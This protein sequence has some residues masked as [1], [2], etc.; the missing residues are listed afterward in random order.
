MTCRRRRRRAGAISRLALGAALAGGVL[1]ALAVLS[2]RAVLARRAGL[3]RRAGETFDRSAD[4]TTDRDVPTAG[5]TSVPTAE[6]STGPTADPTQ[7]RTGT[8]RASRRPRHPVRATSRIQRGTELARLGSRVAGG[9]AGDSARQVF[10]SAQR[11]EELRARRQL[12]T[13]DEVVE[14][15]GSMKGAFMKLGQM[16][17]YL[18]ATLDPEVRRTLAQLQAD[19]PPMSAEL[20][21]S[22]IEGELGTRPERLFA[23]WDPEPLAAASIGQ[24]HKA[25]TADGQ[26]V[27]VKVQYPGVDEAIRS[28]LDN[29]A[30]LLSVI[31]LAFPSLDAKAVVAELRER[32]G[33]ELDYGLEARNQTLFADHYAGHPF[34]H[35][36]AVRPDLS[37]RRVLT[38]ELVVGARYEEV[39]GWPQEQRNLAGEAIFRF[40]FGGLYQMHVFN[41]DPHP[42]NYLFHGDGR[43][44]FLDFGL[45]KWFEP[46]EVD[47]LA[48]MVESAVL[49][50]DPG[51]FR[52][53][54]ERAG[55]LKPDP[56]LTDEEVAAYF[57]HYYELVT[58]DR[59]THFSADYAT[60]TLRHFFDATSPVVRRANVPSSFVVLQRINLGLYAVLAGLEASGNWRRVAEEIWPWV[61]AP[62]STELGRADAEWRRRT[63]R[64]LAPPRRR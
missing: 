56:T 49:D 39:L 16:A 35:V 20:A 27:A 8:A 54:V 38:S 9:Y 17:S 11:R 41:G 42:G 1:A 64:G 33:E 53:A 28:D 10:A 5:P 50:P 23:E 63:G 47:L 22:V 59:V 37:S 60:D 31:R 36:P 4:S 7:S 2:R 57:D 3:P 24:V 34:I 40:V 45:V 51:R 30:T 18:D 14:T 55:F 6:R 25:I 61:G 43:V 19:A 32:I 21:G 62:P 26:A 29:S 52:A 13:T 58:E 12:R 44:T 48:A 46:V 15:L